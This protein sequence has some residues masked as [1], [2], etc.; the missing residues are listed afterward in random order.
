VSAE[1][2]KTIAKGRNTL[3]R[4]QPLEKWRSEMASSNKS[5]IDKNAVLETLNSILEM[6]LGG[7]IHYTHY[8]FVVFGHSRIPIVSWLRDQASQSMTHANEAGDL[9]TAHGG[10]PSMNVGSLS[11]SHVK[12]IDAMLQEMLDHENSG[13]RL[14]EKLLSQ[15]EA[16][17]VAL[18]EYARRMIH[19]ES[20]DIAEI[21]KML[22]K[23]TG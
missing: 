10:Y 12:T 3:M 21:E 7:A 20:N 16:R 2:K 23:M 9:I 5:S 14:Y 1:R 17:H 19:D 6:E 4:Y 8:S 18:E 11:T 22:R 15:V 13:L